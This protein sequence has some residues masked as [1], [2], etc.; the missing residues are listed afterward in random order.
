MWRHTFN[1]QSNGELVSYFVPIPKYIH[2]KNIMPEIIRQSL[3]L[4]QLFEG[5]MYAQILTLR[6]Y[7]MPTLS[8]AFLKLLT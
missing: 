6:S 7:Y 1:I 3:N 4:L 5:Y 8:V 2:D